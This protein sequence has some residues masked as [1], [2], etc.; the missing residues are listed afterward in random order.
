MVLMN[1]VQF[2][3][4]TVCINFGIYHFNN[5]YIFTQHHCLGQD[6]TQGQFLKDGLISI[7]P[8]IYTKLE[9]EQRVTS[10][11]PSALM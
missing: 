11:I 2:P 6:M 10:H 4:E 8:T 3:A 9:G 1:R 5:E 7:L